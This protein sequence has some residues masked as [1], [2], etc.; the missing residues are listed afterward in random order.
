MTRI[1]PRLLPQAR[2]V[3]PK[4]ESLRLNIIPKVS[5]MFITSLAMA[6]MNRTDTPKPMNAKT[7]L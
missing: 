6:L 2:I 3:R 4:I 5:N 7:L 1:P